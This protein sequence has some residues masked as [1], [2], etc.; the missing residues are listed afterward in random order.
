MAG[1]PFDW[2]WVGDSNEALNQAETAGE[3]GSSTHDTVAR[4]IDNGRRCSSLRSLREAA[5]AVDR[6]ALMRSRLLP[7][8][9]L[10]LL[11]SAH[12]QGA[13]AQTSSPSPSPSAVPSPGADVP[14]NASDHIVLSGR[15]VVP[16]GQTVGE[17]VVVTGRVQVAG[18]VLGDVVLVDGPVLIAGQVSGSVVSVDGS[19]RLA[20]TAQVGGD[21]IARED[22]D[23]AEGARVGG[24][25]RP[26]APFTFKAPARAIGRFATWLAV[27]VSTLLLGLALLW[28][29]P[30][31]A[32][33]I[34]RAARETPWVSAAWGLGLAI[35]LPALS[36]L[37]L[38]SLVALP[39]GLVVTLALAFLLYV[40]YTWSV[41]V[42]GRVVVKDRG[43]VP[44][45]LA[46]WAIARVV[47]LIPVVSGITF[48]LAATFGLGA[49]AVAIWRA[50]GATPR[51]GG[52]H[53]RGYVSSAPAA[54]EH[55]PA[56]EPIA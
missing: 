25:V 13:F 46:G 44:A 16:R 3:K 14:T 55:A 36:A 22:V 19:V 23:V 17:I 41:W 29:V 2:A 42:L 40:A 8:A 39:L 51:R 53:R 5:D 6:M 45:F 21:V 30:R 43:R 4:T 15:V 28:L 27:S 24:E 7:I 48:G 52:S 12:A 37:L 49:T 9:S 18:V 11:L 38:L 1:H 31:G 33:R 56:A 47:G 34:L 32:D 54:E 26:H 10:V 35:A 50:R 20:E